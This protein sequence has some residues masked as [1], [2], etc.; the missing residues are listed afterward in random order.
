MNLAIT[1]RL[2]D[3]DAYRLVVLFNFYSYH[4]LISC[5]KDTSSLNTSVDQNLI[6]FQ[7]GNPKEL[8]KNIKDKIVYLH[9]TGMG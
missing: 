6:S 2:C 7:M 8:S 5:L 9:K 1:D 3:M 4:K